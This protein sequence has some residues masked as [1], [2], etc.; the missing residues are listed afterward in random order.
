MQTPE[1]LS[2][3]FW[4][5]SL[6][7]RYRPSLLLNKQSTPE[8][9]LPPWERISSEL[10][11]SA[12][13]STSI[14]TASASL[15][16]LSRLIT[17]SSRT[18]FTTSGASKP[19][20]LFSSSCIS[21]LLVTVMGIFRA[22]LGESFN[23]SE[24]T[25]VLDA[26]RSRVGSPSIS[27]VPS[28]QIREET[29]SSSLRKGG[30]SPLKVRA[31]HDES[32]SL[33][34]HESF[35]GLWISSQVSESTVSLRVTSCKLLKLFS[36]SHAA[37]CKSA[38]K[39]T[40]CVWSSFWTTSIL[41]SIDLRFTCCVSFSAE[42]GIA[43]E[44]CLNACMNGLSS[45]MLLCSKYVSLPLSVVSSSHFSFPPPTNTI[46]SVES[47]LLGKSPS[48]IKS[49]F[50]SSFPLSLVITGLLSEKLDTVC[51]VV[52]IFDGLSVFC[53]ISRFSLEQSSRIKVY[54]WSLCS[55]LVHFCF[56]SFMTI[57][58]SSFNN[59]RSPTV[60][61]SQL[62]FIFILQLFPCNVS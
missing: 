5:Q 61:L 22:S 26:A 49:R 41:L 13:L 39:L 27:E 58:S 60:T 30:F 25:E 40:I 7:P 14:S 1:L 8:R 62:L 20:S 18:E 10:L 43:T 6:L 28:T 17:F 52:P 34:V 16:C 38:L 29:T 57:S 56:C 24:A 32:V 45:P 2:T 53:P 47:L 23:W 55:L 19:N 46:S 35:N 3:V 4:S 21:T 9:T 37:P 15:Y 54:N 11:I 31:P 51:N 33:S 42:Q 44:W 12:A 48:S 50:S 59:N 36:L